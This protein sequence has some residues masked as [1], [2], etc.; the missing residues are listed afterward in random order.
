[1]LFGVYRLRTSH[2]RYYIYR[3]DTNREGFLSK[4][5]NWCSVSEFFRKQYGFGW[6]TKEEA[7]SF[8]HSYL[9]S[10]P[11]EEFAA[12][13]AIKMNDSNDRFSNPYAVYTW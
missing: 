4:E 8:L 11:E 2:G 1:M 9:K 12:L 6:K 13:I 5:G 10:L 3:N 7:I